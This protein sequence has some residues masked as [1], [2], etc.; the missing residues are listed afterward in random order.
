MVDGPGPGQVFHRKQDFAWFVLGVGILVLDL[1]ADHEFDQL[2]LRCAGRDGGD[3]L[4]VTQDGDDVP[5]ALDL[6]HVMGDE[7]HGHALLLEF[8]HDEEKLLAFLTGQGGGRLVQDE[9]GCVLHQGFGDFHHL[10]AGD[11]QFAH[12]LVHVFLETDA[13]QSPLGLLA[14]GRPVDES[15]MRRQMPQEEVLHD[16][17][18]RDQV[19]LLVD[20]GYAQVP[21]GVHIGDPGLFPVDLD[22][23]FVRLVDAAHHLDDGRFPGPVLPKEHVDLRRVHRH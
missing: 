13:G 19:E 1:P 7:D 12:R 3:V 9:D 17:Q 10:L 18:L 21:G 4:A 14:H 16:G 23:P 8:L 15:S 11:A 5:D 2:R 22:M 6:I 20:D